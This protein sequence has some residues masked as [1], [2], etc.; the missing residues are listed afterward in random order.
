MNT[1]FLSDLIIKKVI[2][3][4]AVYTEQG[5]LTKRNVRPFWGIIYKFEGE[6]VYRSKNKSY[7]SNS[8]NIVILPKGSSYEWQCVKG[9]RYRCIEFDSDRSFDEILTFSVNNKE[10]LLG[11]FESVEQKILLKKYI[12]DIEL[13]RDVYSILIN[14]LGSSEKKYAPSLKQ[15][16]IYPAIEYIA[17]NYNKEIK[18][19]DLASLVGI[20]TVYFRKLFSE[21]YRTSPIAYIHSLR[22]SKAKEMLLGEY[23]SITD[24]ALSLGYA[25]IYDFSR[26]FKRIAGISPKKYVQKRKEEI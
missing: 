8:D 18:N 17:K 9:G 23:G 7:I 4:S 2:S 16:K 6:T 21:I 13:I 11:L 14:V 12:G 3:S 19:D 15:Q 25:N 22:I 26:T 1:E 24:I 5:K 10:K 20:S